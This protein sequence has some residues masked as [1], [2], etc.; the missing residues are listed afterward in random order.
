MGIHK[1]GRGWEFRKFRGGVGV[2][3]GLKRDRFRGNELLVPI[4]LGSSRCRCKGSYEDTCIRADAGERAIERLTQSKHSFRLV[5]PLLSSFPLPVDEHG[6]W[7][8]YHTSRAT[9]HPPSIL[10]HHEYSLHLERSEYPRLRSPHPVVPPR[11]P[12]FV[13][14]SPVSPVVRETDRGFVRIAPQHNVRGRL[15]LDRLGEL[16]FRGWE[17]RERRSNSREK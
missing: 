15:L 7:R 5:S 3:R 8:S 13:S 12:Q 17:E 14:S 11:L 6:R 9:H 2:R 10:A 1:R 16:R 4:S